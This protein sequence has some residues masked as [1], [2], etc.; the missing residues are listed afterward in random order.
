[1][2]PINRLFAAPLEP[3]VL[4]SMLGDLEFAPALASTSA[5]YG[6]ACMVDERDRRASRSGPRQSPEVWPLLLGAIVQPSPWER[7][8]PMFHHLRTPISSLGQGSPGHRFQALL[9]RETSDLPLARIKPIGLKGARP[10]AD[11]GILTAEQFLFQAAMPDD[12]KQLADKLNVETSDI[13]AWVHLAEMAVVYDFRGLARGR[14]MAPGPPLESPEA[15]T[16]AALATI[17][18]VE[19]LTTVNAQVVATSMARINREL[20]IAAPIFGVPQQ[21]IK[22]WQ[23]AA[24]GWIKNSGNGHGMVVDEPSSAPPDAKPSCCCCCGDA[25]GTP[26]A[27]APSAPTAPA[28]AKPGAS[29]ASAAKPTQ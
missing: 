21:L 3:D 8:E 9:S 28:T 4:A 10:L 1:M 27:A 14:R 17:T 16:L 25:G 20:M 23:G 29:S 5:R 7:T 24:T 18:S 26:A 6:L 19:K 22:D 2:S 15:V 12:R 11:A 13:Q